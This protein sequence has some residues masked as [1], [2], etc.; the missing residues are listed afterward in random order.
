[1]NKLIV[2]SGV[3]GSGKSYISI[4]LKERMRDGHIYVVSSDKI[5]AQIGGNQQNF[6]N[7]AL[8][9]K[10]YYQLAH[11]YANDPDGIVVL[12]STNAKRIYRINAVKQL[13]PLFDEIDLVIFKLDKVT[14]MRQ[15][16]DR[17]YP[18]P[19]SSL[20]KLIDEFEDINK[21]DE[22]F[23]DKIYKVDKRDLSP[24]INSLLNK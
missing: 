8:T 7:E 10:M 22:D 13:K 15:N 12:D 24:I 19:S 3:P 17:D 20:E 6:N 16:L 4:L 18:I 9:W 21:E 2:L 11:V 23:F 1:M 14:V 5:R